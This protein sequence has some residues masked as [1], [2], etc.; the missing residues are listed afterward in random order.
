M[1][2]ATVA[3][4]QVPQDPKY[5]EVVVNGEGADL[6]YTY[7]R[8]APNGPW[9]NLGRLVDCS[10]SND[11]PPTLGPNQL[12]SQGAPMP[13]PLPPNQGQLF[14][15]QPR[16]SIGNPPSQQ[17]FGKWTVRSVPPSRTAATGLCS[18]IGPT[19]GKMTMG[20]HSSSDGVVI[21]TL[22]DARWR[23]VAGNRGEATV[24]IGPKQW[25]WTFVRSA[26]N[27]V[28]TRLPKPEAEELM[29]VFGGGTDAIVVTVGPE[30][31]NLEQPSDAAA[32][33]FIA[34]ALAQSQAARPNQPH[35]FAPPAP[36]RR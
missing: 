8:T 16:A 19:G 35:R 24:Q 7:V 5:H 31:Y 28:A 36:A 18:Q 6:A 14:Q 10:G 20:L 3:A 27:Q 15:S 25:T 33:A 34:C 26:P 2:V 11:S 29:A 21:L 17:V 12:A 1:V 13:P 30:H 23:L 22:A 32:N 9:T 4:R